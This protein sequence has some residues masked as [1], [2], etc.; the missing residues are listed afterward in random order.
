MCVNVQSF[1]VC[2]LVSTNS[3]NEFR[4]NYLEKIILDK[5]NE[6]ISYDFPQDNFEYFRGIEKSSV[7]EYGTFDFIIVGSGSTGSVL[8]RRLSFIKSWRILLLEAGEQYDAFIDIP[9]MYSFSLRSKHNWGYNTTFQKYGCKGMVNNQCS[10]PRGKIL[11]GSSSINGLIY[12]RGNPQDYDNWE[13]LGN[14]GW[15]YKNVE[16]YF[17]KLENTQFPS[18]KLGRSGP[19]YVNYSVPYVSMQDTFSEAFSEKGIFETEYNGEKQFG[20]SKIQS[21]IKR[22]KRVSGYNAYIK[23][24]SQRTNLNVSTEAFVIKILIDDST[25]KAYGVRFVKKG[26]IFDATSV[27][28][29][30][31]SAGAINSPQIL[32]LSGIGPEHLLNEYNIPLV[33]DL[34]VGDN[35]LDQIAYNIHFSSNYTQNTIPL[36]KQVEDFLRG[37]GLFTAPFNGKSLSF[38]KPDDLGR[39]TVE[40]VLLPPT[41]RNH[42]TSRP[43]A[44]PYIPSI[45]EEMSKIDPKNF[46]SITT[47]ILHPKSKGKVTIR[48]NKAQDFPEIDSNIFSNEED[49]ETLYEAIQFAISITET[50]AFKK[51]NASVYSPIPP[52][53]EHILYSKQYWYCAIRYM[54]LPTYHS[55]GTTSMGMDEKTSVVNHELKIHGI[56]NL[57]VADCGVIPATIS[58]H[59]NGPAFMIGEKLSSIIKEEYKAKRA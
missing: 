9:S 36:S 42:Y 17:R 29:V 7:D 3:A 8:A 43:L 6:A 40:Y 57:R 53:F 32:M 12:T 16:S 23:P 19:L 4:Q 52:C 28:E 38:V 13:K 21:N 1:V 59:T 25:K 51:I 35:L 41:G 31:L 34:P 24:I 55:M 33:K 22:G 18:K 20:T 15:S 54:A 44:S 14:P 5:V 27:K 2:L 47:I 48:S 39:P 50:G 56:K 11:G 26:R 30:I 10:Y 58:G 49:L 45:N 37:E 46:F